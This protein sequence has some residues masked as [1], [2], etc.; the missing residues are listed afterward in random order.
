VNCLDESVGILLP[1]YYTGELPITQ[2]LTVQ[3]HIAGCEA[4]RASL[5]F[6]M[7][8]GGDRSTP[9]YEAGH[10]TPELLTRY[11]QGGFEPAEPA[12]GDLKRHLE[13]C[14]ECRREYRFLIDLES[15]LIA[16]AETEPGQSWRRAWSSFW[17]PVARPALAWV[18]VLIL[19]YPAV[20]WALQRLRTSSEVT[21]GE[22]LGPAH[23]LRE[24]MRGREE[25]VEVVRHPHTE[26]L[27]LALPMYT[28]PD[29]MTY[30]FE[31]Q[32]VPTKEPVEVQMI[33]GYD[34]EGEIDLL[35][36]AATLADGA[37]L[38]TVTER[39]RDSQAERASKSFSF[40]LVTRP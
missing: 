29:T 21:F 26:F 3:S 20:Q 40:E 23:R 11:I 38:I 19:A 1:D 9:V 4:C 16:A 2:W 5:A 37:Y 7:M 24:S 31:F 32:H 15:E 30:E 13:S 6:M 18:L 22:V 28:L 34:V 35:V 36:D 10:V 25:L 27:R 8:L 12:P 17:R 33:A 14:E 39:E